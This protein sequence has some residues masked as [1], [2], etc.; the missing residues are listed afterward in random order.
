MFY[1]SSAAVL[2]KHGN[3]WLEQRI[4]TKFLVKLENN[5]TDKKC[6]SKFIVRKQ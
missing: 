2:Q 6:Y 4:N 3:E 5:G 1:W